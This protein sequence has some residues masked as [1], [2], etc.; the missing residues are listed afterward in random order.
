MSIGT[1]FQTHRRAAWAA[2]A[3]ALAAMVYVSVWFAAA[4]VVQDQTARWIEAQRRAGYSITHD[5]PQVSGFPGTITV[6]YENWVAAA[7]VTHGEWRWR[8]EAIRVQ[9]APWSPL[10]FTVDLAGAHQVAGVWTPLAVAGV[11][12]AAQ[13]QVRPTLTTEGRIGEISAA[14]DDVQLTDGVN[15][16]P[17]AALDRGTFAIRKMA[18]DRSPFWRLMIDTANWRTPM[19]QDFPTF[20]PDVRAFRLTADVTGEVNAAPWP[21]MLQAWREGGGTL[22][23]RELLFDW[24]PLSISATGTAALDD[25]LQPVGALTAT[26]RG[27]FETIDAMTKED[28]VRRDEADT[29]RLVLGLL[30]RTPEGGGPPELSISVTLQNG[31]LYAGP[32]ALMDLPRVQWQTESGLPE[33]QRLR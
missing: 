19:L 16:T 32:I 15:P 6:T 25:R 33:M 9:A 13:A 2:I 7:P 8:T 14:F 29:A 31:K 27:F 30:S 20:R 5:T 1:V 12:T 4:A 26:F 22:E 21:T 10:T 28:L 11:V 18:G 3:F 17:L 24:P 23:V